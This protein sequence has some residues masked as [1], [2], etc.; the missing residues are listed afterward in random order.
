MPLASPAQPKI[1]SKP[2]LLFRP[3][4]VLGWRLTPQASV[5]VRF[6]DAIMQTIGDDGWR[7]VPG[8][9]VARGPRLAFYGCSFTYGTGLAD[10]ETY[11]ALLQRDLPGLRILNRGIGGHGTVQNLLQLRRDIAAG[12]VDAA[13]FAIISDHRFRN[14]PHPQRMRQYLSPEWYHLGV[15]HVP[16]ARM[17]ATGQVRI[18]YLP[19]WQPAMNAADF[20]VFLPDDWMI[21][22]ATLA[23]LDLVR[24]TAEAAGVPLMFV[25]LDAQDADFSAAVCG[26]FA[27]AH[28]ISTPHDPQ[29]T[30]LPQNA[31]PNMQANRLFAQRLLPLVTTLCEALPVGGTR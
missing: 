13:V 19:L 28:D 8:S 22:M 6:R 2:R 16:V 30:F 23:V 21:T 14:I 27:Q 31:H 3:D 25:L 26:R 17:D 12:A 18:V 5:R 1:V 15:E 20:T 29:H 4:A 7:H 11:T 24:Q 10:D 9:T